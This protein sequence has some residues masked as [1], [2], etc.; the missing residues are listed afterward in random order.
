[1]KKLNKLVVDEVNKFL[2]DFNNDVYSPLYFGWVAVAAQVG[3][4]PKKLP[5]YV[6]S[7]YEEWKGVCRQ[8]VITMGNHYR[9]GSTEDWMFEQSGIMRFSVNIEGDGKNQPYN[10]DCSLSITI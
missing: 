5:V 7:D 3:H 4:A 9:N 1:M 6:P 10:V 2:K 8:L